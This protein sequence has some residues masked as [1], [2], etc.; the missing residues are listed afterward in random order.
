MLHNQTAW[1]NQG[2][3]FRI[4][5]FVQQSEDVPVNRLLPKP[6]ACFE[7]AA[8]HSGIDARVKSS[9]VEGNEAA[10]RIPYDA[11]LRLPCWVLPVASSLGTAFSLKPIHSRENLLDFVTNNVPA[12]LESLSVNPFAM[13]LVSEAVQLCIAGP[14]I[15]PIDEHRNKHL[16]SVFSQAAGPL[17][18]RRQAGR[19]P[20]QHFGSLVRVSKG[21]DPRSG[22]ERRC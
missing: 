18:F 11:D 17:R 4:A 6:L 9:G 2:G 22:H 14:R 12:H 7:V 1:G 15:P 20:Y 5:K 13:R 10:F 19:Q 3:N 8:D 21:D 16:A